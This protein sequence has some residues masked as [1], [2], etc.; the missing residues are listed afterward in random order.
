MFRSIV[1]RRRRGGAR[2]SAAGLLA[3]E[4]RRAGD[5][6]VEGR[7][8][9]LGPREHISALDGRDDHRGELLGIC[10]GPEFPGFDPLADD[11]GESADDPPESLGDRAEKLRGCQHVGVVRHA[12]HA[13]APQRVS[14]PFEVGDHT[15]GGRAVCGQ[16]GLRLGAHRRGALLQGRGSQISLAREVVVHASLAHVGAVEDFFGAGR[17]VPAFP[18]EVLRDVHQPGSSVH[19]KI[20]HS[21]RYRRR[22]AKGARRGAVR[23]RSRGIQTA[24]RAAHRGG[25][26][27]HK[28]GL[29]GGGRL[30]NLIPQALLAQLAEQLTLNQWVLGSSPRRCTNSAPR[31]Q[32]CGAFRFPGRRRMRRSAARD[33]I[34]PALRRR[35]AWARFGMRSGCRV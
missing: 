3:Y 22:T 19:A 14:L 32:G 16:K 4:R 26:R 18:Q 9:L 5:C 33:P 12:P 2:S 17:R 6:G 28:D 13:A 25:A 30:S 24:G 20:V 10:I 27:S 29:R 8:I 35:S 31:P 23:V 21:G 34:R 11:V 1:S 7:R 15:F